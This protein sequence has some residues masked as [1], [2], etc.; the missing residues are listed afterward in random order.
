MNAIEAILSRRSIRK[1]ADQPVPEQFLET[2]LKAAMSAPSA[3]NEQLWQFV[4]IRERQ[5]LDA[6]PAV[7]PHSAMLKEAPFAVIICG[8]LKLEKHR[9]FIPQRINHK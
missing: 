4:V 1:Y 5:T 6:I 8:D 7:H 9:L 3:G 2:L